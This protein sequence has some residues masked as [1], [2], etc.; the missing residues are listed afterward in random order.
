VNWVF[1]GGFQ[2]SE[3]TLP[4]FFLDFESIKVVK[5]MNLMSKLEQ[6]II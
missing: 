3:E 1:S 4:V 6:I 2:L 5:L